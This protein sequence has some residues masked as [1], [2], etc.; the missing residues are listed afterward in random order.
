MERERSTLMSKRI[1]SFDVEANGLHGEGFAVGAA[2]I[3]EDGA[4]RA[5][6]AG[7]APIQ[8]EVNPWVAENVL[9]A[10]AGMEVTHASAAE[11]RAALW[12]WREAK[13][14]EAKAAGITLIEVADIG[15]PVEARFLA[16]CQDDDLAGRAWGGPYPLHEVATLLLAAG[17]DPDVNREEYAA[18][19]LVGREV[20]KHHPAWDAEVSAQCALKALR[21]LGRA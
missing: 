7:R 12:A 16:A 17:V 5:R 11:L 6:F 14:L 15:Y 18:D 9:P 1:L 20:R 8:G 13:Q 2:V 21:A 3:E 4:V 10:L 19:A